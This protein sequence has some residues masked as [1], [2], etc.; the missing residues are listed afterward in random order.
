MGSNSGSSYS[1]P[2]GTPAA[3]SAAAAPVSS[4]VARSRAYSVDALASQRRISYW[5]IGVGPFVSR[6]LATDN[7]MY[8]FM[9]GHQWDINPLA[10]IKLFSEANLSS[11]REDSHFLNFGTGASYFL[12]T[13]S[14]DTG[15]Y[16]TADIGYGFARDA[17]SHSAEGFSFGTGVGVQFFRTTETTLDLL[18]RYAVIL[19]NINPGGN[20]SVTGLR[21]AV[22]F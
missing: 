2:Y 8:D 15:P 6:R 19:D 10:S 22:N 20:P 21:L 12:P 5:S 4:D 13:G 14:P 17:E 18:F 16:V 1:A 11:G 7:V 3:D 9:L